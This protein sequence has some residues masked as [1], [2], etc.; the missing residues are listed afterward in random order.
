MK[1][2]LFLAAVLLLSGCVVPTTYTKTVSVK[3]DVDGKIV[4]TFE[5]ES[6]TQPRQH[7]FPIKFQY[8]EGIQPQPLQF[9]PPQQQL[10]TKP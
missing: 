2:A 9:L 8:F 4:E 10:N 5:T 7:G 6:V 1:T 3:R